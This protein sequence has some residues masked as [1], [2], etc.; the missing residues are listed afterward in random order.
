MTGLKYKYPYTYTHTCQ[1]HISHSQTTTGY[2]NPNQ[3]N[4]SEELSWAVLS[5]H[6]PYIIISAPKRVIWVWRTFRFRFDYSKVS[7]GLRLRRCHRTRLLLCTVGRLWH[8]KL[9]TDAVSLIAPVASHRVLFSL[10]ESSRVESIRVQWVSVS[11]P[12]P[13]AC[14]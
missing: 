11:R 12:V 2:S 14:Q 10:V 13:K 4:A 3:Q 6:W 7:N 8:H 5:V 9:Q 1:F